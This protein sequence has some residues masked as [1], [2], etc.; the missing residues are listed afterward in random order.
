MQEE[1]KIV[2][3]GFFIKDIYGTIHFYN[4]SNIEYI[5]CTK[6]E[7]SKYEFYIRFL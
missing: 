2:K 7:D 3:N 4:F 6:K 1:L 5:T